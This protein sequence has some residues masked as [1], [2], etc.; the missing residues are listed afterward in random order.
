MWVLARCFARI[1][2][3]EGYSSE[4]IK[5]SC[6][7]VVVDQD[8]QVIIPVSSQC[9]SSAIKTVLTYELLTVVEEFWN[10]GL[11]PR[12]LNVKMAWGISFRPACFT[13]VLWQDKKTISSWQQLSQK[14]LLN[15]CKC[16]LGKGQLLEEFYSF[17]MSREEV[18][19]WVILSVDTA[20]GKGKWVF[21]LGCKT[22]IMPVNSSS[23]LWKY[24]ATKGCGSELHEFLIWK[25]CYLEGL[26]SNTWSL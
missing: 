10:S 24:S 22:R 18:F 8:V 19:Y 23:R 3:G 20:L 14:N 21:M 4:S 6:P 9:Q 17:K 5:S 7:A 15:F 16:T 2:H 13:L 1:R 12:Y 26:G 11:Y 25:H